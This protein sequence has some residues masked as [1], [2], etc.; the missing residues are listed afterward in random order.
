VSAPETLGLCEFQYER[1]TYTQPSSLT[2]RRHCR[3]C[4]IILHRYLILHLSSGS[5]VVFIQTLV[6]TL[7]PARSHQLSTKTAHN[8]PRQP[9][10]CPLT[11]HCTTA[12]SSG[13]QSTTDKPLPTPSIRPSSLSSLVTQPCRF[14]AIAVGGKAVSSTPN[15]HMHQT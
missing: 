7:N 15:R 12:P 10:Q 2:L 4:V 5:F 14:V 8:L 9:K 1:I 13:P 6:S 3:P 11:S